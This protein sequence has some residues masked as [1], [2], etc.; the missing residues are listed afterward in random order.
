MR[1]ASTMMPM[2]SYDNGHVLVSSQLKA[3]I[4][5]PNSWSSY[6]SCSRRVIEDMKRVIEKKYLYGYS[7]GHSQR[8]WESSMI[9]KRFEYGFTRIK[10]PFTTIGT[11]TLD[12]HIPIPIG[13]TNHVGRKVKPIGHSL[14]P[15]PPAIHPLYRPI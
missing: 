2:P 3:A 8:N 13:L 9:T 10:S 7:L 12:F 4:K 5:N 14:P 15:P 1:V 6:A 11:T